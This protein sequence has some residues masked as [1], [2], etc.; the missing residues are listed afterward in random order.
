MTLSNE[1]VKKQLESKNNIGDRGISQYE[2][3]IYKTLRRYWGYSSFL[4]LQ[5][6]T[7]LSILK[8]EDSLTV[9]PTG[10]G[11]SLCFQ[12]PALLKQGMAVVVSPL[13]S[14]M[15]DQVDNLQDM[16]I[17]SCYLNSSLLITQKRAVIE[18]IQKRKIKL[19]Y[20]SPE[21]LE[22]I[23]TMNMLS[24]VGISFFVIDE[25][26][27]ISHWG[28]DFRTSYRNLRMIKEKFKNINTHA[29]TATATQKVQSDVIEQLGVDNPKIYVG[30]M[31]RPNLTY[32]VSSRN[33]ILEQIIEVLEKHTDEAG[34]IYCLRRRDVDSISKS[35]K[36]RGIDNLPYHAGMSD[37]ERRISQEKFTNEEVNIIVAT[38]AFGMGIN[39]SNI[40]FVIHAGMPKSI[41]H[42][43][44]ET[45]RA[46][47]D[48]LPASCYMF[49]GGGDYQLW[50]FFA[51]Q[52][53]NQ[54]TMMKKL[55]TI[56]NFCAQPQC[57]HKMLSNY[58]G[59]EYKKTSCLACDY[60]LNEIDMVEDASVIGEKILLAV[61]ETQQEAYGFGA[62]Y[63]KDVLKGKITEKV[64]RMGHEYLPIFGA[65]NEKSEKF[66]Y[67]AIE[68]L[69]GQGF[70]SKTGEF[71]TLS[72]TSDGER[73]LQGEAEPMLAK[74]LMSTKKKKISKMIRARKEIEWAEIDQDLFQALRKKRSELALKKRVPAYIIFGDKSLRDMA[75]QK[76]VTREE[77]SG[78]YG[79]GENKMNSYANIFIK[80]IK[81]YK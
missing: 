21:R 50:S 28:H 2:E 20:I 46:G 70:L 80:L 75:S 63:V 64:K 27:C 16:G 36:M 15:K 73:L 13:I 58:F 81:D 18:L 56:Y 23:E 76:P 79:V 60:C 62:N 34:I 33:Q 61:A 11:K 12:L 53:S 10:G 8:G 31:D 26:H 51:E 39:H 47:R 44:Q 42:Y 69:V 4:P 52:S 37:K 5:K 57:R 68:Q 78:I 71:P 30:L 65:M 17:A 41:E 7:I 72:I 32:R 9:L 43:Q 59:Q 6:E 38:I 77:F 35:L 48:G 22:D 29:F 49:Y 19:L 3:Q 14:L 24:S 54:E 40:R 1:N 74:P 55:N 45:G 67:Y 25:A 66:I